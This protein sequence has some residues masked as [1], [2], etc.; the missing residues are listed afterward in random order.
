MIGGVARWLPCAICVAAYWILRRRVRLA[1][2]VVLL[3]V[4]A[5]AGNAFRTMEE[6]REGPTLISF[7]T[8][9]ILIDG[10]AVNVL[11]GNLLHSAVTR[12]SGSAT[13]LVHGECA[14]GC[15]G[16]K[17]CSRNVSAVSLQAEGKSESLGLSNLTWQSKGCGD[18]EL[19]VGGSPSL[20]A[21]LAPRKSAACDVA[22]QLDLNATTK[23]LLS[24]N[25]AS[26]AH[27]TPTVNPG[28][29]VRWHTNGPVTLQLAAASGPLLPR[30]EVSKV[31]QLVGTL[32]GPVP[33][34]GGT[35]ARSVCTAEAGD[36]ISVSA[37]EWKIFGLSL[38]DSIVTVQVASKGNGLKRCANP[39]A[40]LAPLAHTGDSPL[41]TNEVDACGFAWSAF[42]SR[43]GELSPY[44]LAVLMITI[45]GFEPGRMALLRRAKKRMTSRTP[46][47]P[48]TASGSSRGSP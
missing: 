17:E 16:C 3:I 20:E 2:V 44:S 38:A 11:E 45:L 18:T 39:D 8:V 9:S 40:V 26:G 22:M 33:R 14:G 42:S 5:T 19:R 13:S 35:T 28:A 37:D 31:E 10:H 41:C 6:I 27:K 48:T 7:R 34:L 29:V 30:N 47:P 1:F 21:I 36:K 24:F 43:T 4:F 23:P 15:S 12:L 46:K 25:D 32:T